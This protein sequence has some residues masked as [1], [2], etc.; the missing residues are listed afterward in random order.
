[1]ENKKE[2]EP[3]PK[4]AKEPQAKPQQQQE[5]KFKPRVIQATEEKYSGEIISLKFKDADLR[6]V[7]LFLADF[8]GFERD[9]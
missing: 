8:A 3:E 7:I 6:D 2:A 1:V 4:M 9:L 5:D